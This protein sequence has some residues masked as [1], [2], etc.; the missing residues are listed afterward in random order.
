MIRIPD[1][2]PENYLDFHQEIQ[3]LREV[4]AYMNDT[5]QSMIIDQTHNGGGY[6]DYV[7]LLAGLFADKEPIKTVSARIKLS[8][9]LLATYAEQD[10]NDLYFN[11]NISNLQTN[12]EYLNYLQEL[13]KLG[14]KSGIM[15][16]PPLPYQATS[17]MRPN[18]KVG[19]ATPFGGVAYKKGVLILNDSQSGSGGD[20]FPAIMQS[21]HRAVIM[22]ETSMGLGGPVF[23]E[24]DSRSS[25]E[26]YLRMTYG[27]AQVND[28]TFIENKGVVPDLRR[29]VRYSDLLPQDNFT[30]Y[31][32]EV[33]NSAFMLA[34]GD[35]PQ[36]IQE[37]LDKSRTV[38]PS[39]SGLRE[40]EVIRQQ[41]NKIAMDATLK[42]VDQMGLY[43]SILKRYQD[44][45]K[46]NPDISTSLSQPYFD[47]R[48]PNQLT[49]RDEFL[50]SQ[51][52]SGAVSERLIEILQRWDVR[53]RLDVQPYNQSFK[54]QDLKIFIE[55]V[56]GRLLNDPIYTEQ[57]RI[58]SEMIQKGPSFWVVPVTREKITSGG[59]LRYTP[60]QPAEAQRQKALAAKASA[61]LSKAEQAAM[62]VSTKERAV[63]TGQNAHPAMTCEALFFN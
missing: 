63:Q 24:E 39:V 28:G 18:E 52:M 17:P 42:P 55:K 50:A 30:S 41:L 4:V 5:T 51:N 49:A 47:I 58:L 34:R 32:T 43:I 20:F 15:M 35:S 61:R 38:N 22:G 48:L 37:I 2:S 56:W 59:L 29:Q 21:N 25:Y 13:Y 16:T 46:A 45:L 54:A 33:L 31:A 3:W 9:T 44:T 57:V 1:Y 26:M 7:A 60:E 11:K 8:E 19:E 14:L 62:A 36:Q 27:L 23:R 40:L 53:D 6:V 12:Q 10:G